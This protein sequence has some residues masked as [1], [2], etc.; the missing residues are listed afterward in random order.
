MNKIKTI[1]SHAGLA[2]WLAEVSEEPI[3]WIPRKAVAD[4]PSPYAY[5]PTKPVW[6]WG[7]K[8]V[9]WFETRHR[10]YEVFELPARFPDCYL[11]EELASDANFKA[12]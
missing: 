9:I 7:E 2:R 8:F 12:D 4:I 11:T 5:S 10:Y 1:R 3:G 6:K